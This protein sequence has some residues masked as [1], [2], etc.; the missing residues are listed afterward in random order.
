MS[1]P[2]LKR[3]L[4]LDSMSTLHQ[5]IL[6]LP[7]EC[8]LIV[9]SGPIVPR[10][11]CDSSRQSILTKLQRRV[12]LLTSKHIWTLAQDSSI[13][14]EEFHTDEDTCFMVHLELERRL[15]VWH[16]QLTSFL[17]SISCTSPAFRKIRSLSGCSRTY[18]PNV[19]EPGSLTPKRLCHP[20]S[21][22]DDLSLLRTRS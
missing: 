11:R 10:D 13:L 8:R 6:L 12:L 15:C 4:V 19:S 21:I 7:L 5:K 17:T 3:A 22:K 9:C 20:L 16:L 18:R 1:T 2:I 14:P